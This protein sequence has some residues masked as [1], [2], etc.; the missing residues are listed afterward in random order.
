MFKQRIRTVTPVGF[1]NS[2]YPTP[3]STEPSVQSNLKR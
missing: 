2:G 3:D 1:P